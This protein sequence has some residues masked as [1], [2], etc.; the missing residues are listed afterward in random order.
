[1][2]NFSLLDD[3]AWGNSTKAFLT[4]NSIYSRFD[5]LRE[6]TTPEDAGEALKYYQYQHWNAE[7]TLEAF[8][9][10]VKT[11]Y[12]TAKETSFG[13]WAETNFPPSQRLLKN[14]VSFT[15]NNLQQAAKWLLE[16]WTAAQES[17]DYSDQTLLV[18]SR[19]FLKSLDDYKDTLQEMLNQAYP[20]K[21]THA[22]FPINN[23]DRLANPVVREFLSG[24]DFLK[25]WFKQRK[26]LKI[27]EAGI[28]SFKFDLEVPSYLTGAAAY[29]DVQGH[30]IGMFAPTAF[31]NTTPRMLD[32]W[33]KEIFL[34]EFGHY[35]HLAYITGEAKAFWDSWWDNIEKVRDIDQETSV[36]LNERR[37]YYDIL[38]HKNFDVKR[39]K[40]NDFSYN[41]QEETNY[42]KFVSWITSPSKHYKPIASVSGRDYTKPPR[43]TPFGEE[44]FEF[45]R[46]S[47]GKDYDK[48]KMEP[49]LTMLG[50][51][52][53]ADR[54]ISEQAKQQLYKGLLPVEQAIAELGVPTNYA[55]TDAL[56]DFAE[57]FVLFVTEPRRL[58]PLAQYRM[59]RTLSLSGLYGKPVM[60]FA[61]T[62]EGLVSKDL[63][64]E[65]QTLMQ[66]YLND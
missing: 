34:H 38:E 20:A 6:A 48:K 65:A 31:L 64:E 14:S 12:P 35:I 9:H 49:Y 58:S 29:Y 47:K 7:Y 10:K 42:I 27:F 57:S 24:I 40:K 37:D 23:P 17:K 53:N 3:T 2:T 55:Q 63:L 1:M 13:T 22:G 66:T 41:H 28:K 46:D 15:T 30:F 39:V 43:V 60:T 16:Y 52:D 11:V 25:R 33:I 26:L 5:E 36:T 50:L 51:F 54:E 44:M 45:F 56:E 32:S 21:F 62:I 61:R 19:G 18:T 59:K 8:A 4:F